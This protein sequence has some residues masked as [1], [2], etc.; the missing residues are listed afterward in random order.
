MGNYRQSIS[1]TNLETLKY[2]LPMALVSLVRVIRKLMH[3]IPPSLH[4]V[5]I[6]TRMQ[7]IESTSAVHR[8]FNLSTS[9]GIIIYLV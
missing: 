5:L 8:L 3:A 9:Y 2:R 1:D 6:A 7:S 4:A